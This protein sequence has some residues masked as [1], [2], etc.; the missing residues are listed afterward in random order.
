MMSFSR[1]SFLASAAAFAAVPALGAVS[2]DVDVAIIGAGAAGIAAARRVAALGRR[3]A[4]IEAGDRVGG[5]CVTDTRI[6]GVPHDLG[7]HWIRQSDTNPVA[8]LAAKS[9]LEIYPAP[10]DQKVRIGLR[11]ARE[12]EM[13]DFLSA[14][15]RSNRAIADAARGKADVSCAQ[16]LPKDLGNW[17]PTVEFVLGPYGCSKDLV[18]V[19]AMD[20][21][22]AADH[23]TD[24]FCRQGYG[25]LLAKLSQGMTVQLS[26]PVTQ[27]EW[28]KGLEVE[29]SRGRISA[30][31]VI[32][33][34]STNV[35]AA[36]KIR[37]TP[38]LPKRQLDAAA[39]LKLG[40]QERVA[41]ELPGNPLGLHN[42]EL[43]FEKAENSR[44]AAILANVSG[45][46]LCHV[47]VGGRFGRDLTADGGAALTAF[48]LDWL[49]D[50]YGSDMKKAVKRT[51][52]TQWDKEPWV[53][54]AMST[55]TPGAQSARRVLMEPLR[56]RIWFAGEAVH[57]TLW[58]TV[59][60]AWESGE[61]AADAAL[62]KMGA[63]KEVPESIRAPARQQRRKRK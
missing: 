51:H 49:S 8:K 18:E 4:L 7:A 59:N 46:T 26:T 1:R 29:T 11:N 6:F 61:R 23:D 56:D 19:S 42:D 14:L 28:G 36:G 52:A 5:R 38:E 31:A 48:A 24:A 27:I 47:N 58:G 32:V 16:A 35:L 50:L 13:E 53:L 25:A 62:R 12:G 10:L 43:V 30:R 55:A 34:V 45:T 44:T 37:F 3:F 40:T 22:K 63:L 9:G 39:K 57:E 17:R 60:G 2:A 21:A 20:F 33:T 54:G 41:L 15:V